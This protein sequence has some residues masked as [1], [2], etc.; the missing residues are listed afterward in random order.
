MEPLN[1]DELNDLLCRWQ[2]PPVPA[3]LDAKVL[4]RE[5]GVA[6]WRWLISGTLRVPVPAG[7]VAVLILVFS[8]F[9]AVSA[10]RAVEKPPHTVTFSDFQPVKQLQPRII[11]SGYEGQ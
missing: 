4:E 8:V 3:R 7:I 5:S 6:G 10:R 1:D 9:W 11:R 2:A